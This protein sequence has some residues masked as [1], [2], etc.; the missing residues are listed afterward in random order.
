MDVKQCM[1][2]NV[3]SVM[4]RKNCVEFELEGL[5]QDNYHEYLCQAGE[6][7]IKIGRM[8]EQVKKIR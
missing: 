4:L 7:K 2:I 1:I 3:W 6:N 8:K 5:C